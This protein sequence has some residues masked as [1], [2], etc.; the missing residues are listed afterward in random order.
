MNNEEVRV[1]P[2]MALPGIV[3]FPETTISLYIFE[4]H[5][6]N[7]VK[8]CLAGN[9]LLGIFL[10]KPGLWEGDAYLPCETIGTCGRIESSSALE[11][12]HLNVAVRGVCR[13]VLKEVVRTQPYPLAR[14]QFIEESLGDPTAENLEKALR[15]IIALVQRFSRVPTSRKINLPSKETWKELFITVTNSVA[16]ILPVAAQKKQLWLSQDDIYSRYR[17]VSSELD[18]LYRLNT[19]MESVPPPTDD[20]RL[21]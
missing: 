6:A 11:E 16:S 10:A 14:T 21:N 13:A 9:R 15:D 5:Y 7:M 2:F 19:I 1:L 8:E 18:R 12:G 3:F 20:P 17:M 4:Q